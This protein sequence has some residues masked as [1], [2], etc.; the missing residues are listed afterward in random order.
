MVSYQDIFVTLVVGGFLLFFIYKTF[1]IY[2]KRRKYRH[3]PG[4]PTNGILGFYLGHFR[5]INAVIK[6]GGTFL[7]LFSE[8]FDG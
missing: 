2:L 7:D 1:D 4:P 8:W 6:N 5:E 3:I